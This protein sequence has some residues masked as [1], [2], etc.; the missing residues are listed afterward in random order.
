MFAELMPLLRNRRLLLTISLVE[1]DTIR[2]TVVP[3]KTSE[4]EDSSIT[5]P[6]AITGT[7]EELDRELPQQLVEFTGAHLQLQSTLAS[8]KAEMD[9]AAKAARDEARK[10]TSKPSN[11]TSPATPTTQA[12][13]PTPPE[14]EPPPLFAL[15]AQPEGT[16][17]KEGC[18]MP[19]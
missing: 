4:T 3:Q 9:A 6:L 5:A 15:Q 13:P 16:A 11:A 7:A 8:A 18:R 2:A 10:K 19:E 14:P 17:T 12:A 1:G